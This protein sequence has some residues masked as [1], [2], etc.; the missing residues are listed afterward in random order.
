[1]L[2]NR[3]FHYDDEKNI[4]LGL[5]VLQNLRLRT[6]DASKGNDPF[7]LIPFYIDKPTYEEFQERMG[8]LKYSEDFFKSYKKKYPEIDE[9]ILRNK[10]FTE[11][12]NQLFSNNSIADLNGNKKNLRRK[13]ATWIRFISFSSTSVKPENEILMWSHYASYHKGLRVTFDT[14]KF[15]STIFQE[16]DMAEVNYQA[17]RFKVNALSVVVQES[18]T[19]EE[20]KKISELLTVKSLGWSYEKEYRWLINLKREPKCWFSGKIDNKDYEFVECPPEAI[21]SVDIGCM[22]DMEGYLVNE[23]QHLRKKGEL[24]HIKVNQCN[25]HAKDFKLD[26]KQL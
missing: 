26:Y 25:I 20:L 24:K 1:M 22:A 21:V 14:S 18:Q 17:E 5:D 6:S 15:D 7:E 10:N 19:D 4:C 13:F 2:L 23:V 9:S 12:Y 8:D 11:I 16:Y 3:Y